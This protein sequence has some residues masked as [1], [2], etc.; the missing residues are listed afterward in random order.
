MNWLTTLRRRRRP[1]LEELEDIR[2]HRTD[3]IRGV[4]AVFGLVLLVLVSILV[5]TLVLQP[6]LELSTLEQELEAA[7]TRLAHEKE[8]EAKAR[9]NYFWM[10]DPEYFEQVARDRA[11]QAKE[12]E[13]IIRDPGPSSLEVKEAA[14]TDR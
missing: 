9:N 7:K 11:S 8:E 10:Q 5:S 14:K 2:E 13:I 4:L 6:L 3:G 1:T 12:G